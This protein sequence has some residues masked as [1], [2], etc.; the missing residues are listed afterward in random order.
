MSI[1]VLFQFNK[2]NLFST[3]GRTLFCSAKLTPVLVLAGGMKGQKG[4]NP[5]R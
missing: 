1:P 2:T 4:E 5:T 3:E